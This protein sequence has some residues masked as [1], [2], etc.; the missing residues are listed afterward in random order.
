MDREISKAAVLRGR[1]QSIIKYFFFAALVVVSVIY[2]RSY[3]SMKGS[4]KDFKIVQVKKGSI[5]STLAASGTIVSSSERVINAPITTEIEQV[6]LQTGAQV[7]I[8][9]LILALDQENTQLEYERLQDELSLRKNNIKRLGLQFDKD[10]ND[11]EYQDEIKALRLD[12]LQA[13]VSDQKRLLKIG[14][15]TQEELESAELKLKIERI[16]KKMLENELKFKRSVNQND[17]DNLT[18]EYNIQSKRLQ[19]LGNKLKETEVRATSE[20]VITWINEDIGKTVNVG[21]PLVKLA[22]LNKFKV[23]AITSERNMSILEVGMKTEVKIGKERLYGQITRILPE[24]ENNSVKFYIALDENDHESL[25]PNHRVEVNVIR[26]QKDDVLVARRG[27]GLKG[28]T[29]QFFYKVEQ[30][31]AK[32]VRVKKGLISSDYFEIIEGLEEG[33]KIIVSETEDFNHMDSFTIKS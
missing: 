3:L 1:L 18:L 32:R 5:Q 2:G 13:Q 31:N 14:G 24:L 8:G 30:Q 21:E 11:L 28:T 4:Q 6:Y 29:T 15:A 25:R 9:D 7:K 12:E 33:D 10:L 17:K 16:E 27:M 22:N 19:E 20:G 26:S 23:E